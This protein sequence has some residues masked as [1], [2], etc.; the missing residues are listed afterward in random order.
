LFQNL[1]PI[2]GEE[3]VGE[4]LAHFPANE[5]DRPVTK[6]YLDARLGEVRAE[7]GALR[8]ELRERLAQLGAELHSET[9]RL[10]YWLPGSIA[11]I[12][13]AIAFITRLTF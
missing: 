9:K 6:D 10:M 12:C 8:G 1:S 3:A 5:G 7:M 4:M 2:V 13:A 11:A